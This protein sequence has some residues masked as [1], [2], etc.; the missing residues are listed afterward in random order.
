MMK[1]SAPL[2]PLFAKKSI[3][4]TLPQSCAGVMQKDEEKTGIVPVTRV[5]LEVRQQ[6]WESDGVTGGAMTDLPI[7]Q[8]Q[9][10]LMFCTGTVVKNIQGQKKIFY[11]TRGQGRIFLGVEPGIPRGGYSP[12]NTIPVCTQL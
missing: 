12:Q 2:R 9:E 10:H 11:K 5:F 8:M 1:F 6:F 4:Q 7:G 3:S